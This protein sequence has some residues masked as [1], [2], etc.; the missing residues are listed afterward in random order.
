MI[1]H[2]IFYYGV[3]SGT[4]LVV[5]FYLMLFLCFLIRQFAPKKTEKKEEL[6]RENKNRKLQESSKNTEQRKN[7]SENGICYLLGNYDLSPAFYD[8][9]LRP[10][11]GVLVVLFFFLLT[12]KLSLLMILLFFLGDFGLDIFLKHYGK[13]Q[14]K[15]IEWDIYKALTNVCLQLN[16]GSYLEDSL[17]MAADGA[18]HPRFSEAM[19]ELVRNM[20]DKSKTT[21]E[22]IQI[23]KTRFC[24]ER[25]MN[26][27]KILETF[28][29]YGPVDNVFADMKAELLDMIGSS[30][31]RTAEDIRN[32]YNFSVGWM[33][34]TTLIICLMAFNIAFSDNPVIS[35]GIIEFINSM[36]KILGGNPA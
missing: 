34:M 29:T 13:A 11:C 15:Q 20:G 6:S 3:I 25:V 33:C 16:T 19:H 10:F 26:F 17:K 7:L 28:I 24:S 23:L 31:N 1:L 21:A 22:S 32:R 4:A 35:N 9:F 5:S 12:K 30:T 2:Q 14:E 8:L 18:I 27:C 36:M